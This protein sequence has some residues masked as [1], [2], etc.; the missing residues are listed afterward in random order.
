VSKAVVVVIVE[1]AAPTGTGIVPEA[2]E[3]IIR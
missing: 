1:M 3:I 2:L